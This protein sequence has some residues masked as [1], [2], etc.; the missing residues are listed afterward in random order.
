MLLVDTEES[1]VEYARAA[2]DFLPK[3][4]LVALAGLDHVQTFFCSSLALQKV[5]EFIVQPHRHPQS[6]ES[7]VTIE[8]L[9]VVPGSPQ[10]AQMTSSEFRAETRDPYLTT[11]VTPVWWTG[12]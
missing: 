6:A 3:G 7:H 11:G 9:D 2:S 4:T 12:S 5:C 1:S 8:K 10:E